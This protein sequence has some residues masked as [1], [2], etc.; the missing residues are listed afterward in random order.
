MTQFKQVQ[1]WFCQHFI[2]SELLDL[3]DVMTANDPVN[4]APSQTSPPGVQ[5]PLAKPTNN[6]QEIKVELDDKIKSNLFFP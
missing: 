2:Y 5:M 6:S 4:E 3:L 1:L